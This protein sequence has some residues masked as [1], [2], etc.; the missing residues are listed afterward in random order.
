M[1]WQVNGVDVAGLNRPDVVQLLRESHDTVT[2]VV[3]R[4]EV[5]EEKENRR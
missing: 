1:L 3:S 2:L 5:M 4:Q